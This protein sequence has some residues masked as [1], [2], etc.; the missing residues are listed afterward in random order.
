MYK[1]QYCIFRDAAFSS[2]FNIK[3]RDYE[4]RDWLA[5][6]TSLISGLSRKHSELPTE[7]S[8]TSQKK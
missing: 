6:K 4:S 7:M 8:C 1:R 2:G 3:E 5:I